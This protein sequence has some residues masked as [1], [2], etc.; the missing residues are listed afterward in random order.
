MSLADE[1]VGVLVK[2]VRENKNMTAL[3]YLTKSVLGFRDHGP[4]VAASGNGGVTVNISIPERMSE[5]EFQDIIN[6]KTKENDE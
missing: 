5:Q 1:M 6:V 4:E 2:E 3:I